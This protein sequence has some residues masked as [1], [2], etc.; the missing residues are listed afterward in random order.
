LLVGSLK[1]SMF[2]V[3]CLFAVCLASVFPAVYAAQTT[4]I[5]QVSSP[6]SG[7][8]GSDNP[9]PV[10][11]TVYY[12][13]TV[14]GDQLVVGILDAD[15]S[16]VR[17]A[18]GVVV[19]STDPCVNEA[20]SLAVCAITVPKT[21]GVERINFQIGGIFGGVRG[22]GRW[23]LN[24]TAVLKDPQGNLIPGSM[25]SRSFNIDLTPVALNIDVPSNVTVSVDGVSQPPGSVSIGVALGR[26]TITVPQLVNVSQS[27][28]L[29]FDH[30]S[31]GNTLTVRTF[32]VTNPATLQA[33]YV[34]Q[35]LLTLIG[36][37]GNA[38]IYIWYDADSNATFSTIQSEQISGLLGALGA[39]S[40]F[41]GWYENGQLVTNSPS[42]TISM[43]K[44][45]TLTAQW[46]MDYSIPAAII[47][48]I[49]I[50]VIIIAFL[51][52]QRR[53]RTRTSR[54]GSKRR[55]KR[56]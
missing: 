53:K 5:Y 47:L 30:W 18:P 20:G 39:R 43:D 1:L 9:L 33:I 41:Q 7:V 31:D 49:I 51:L 46:Q 44:P 15:L 28:R 37:P 2:L 3:V 42:G 24:V 26:H 16:P 12:N 8:A 29:R 54:S 4:T 21:S 17:I 14:T 23:D 40:S 19:S 25:S 55:R 35:N 10:A 11:V 27:T 48:G 36:V 52:L 56:S 6:S 22:P 13:N 32:V 38:T 45:H 34:T 50:V